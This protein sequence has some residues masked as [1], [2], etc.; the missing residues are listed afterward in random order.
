MKAPEDDLERR[1]PIW[2]CMQ[3]LWM[4]TDPAAELDYIVQ[5]CADSDYSLADLQ[6]IYWNEVRPAVAFN[7]WMLPAPEWAGFEIEWLTAR[8]LRRSRFGRR[9]PRPWLHP[10]AARWWRQIE[11]AIR[12]L[13][14]TAQ[15]G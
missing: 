3:M 10:N 5:V 7:L 1:R 4:D 15:Q 14:G 13:R 8:I 11:A 2:D 6:A 9:L 12:Q